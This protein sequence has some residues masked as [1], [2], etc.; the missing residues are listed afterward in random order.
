MK[1]SVAGLPSGHK[2]IEAH[3][4]S[5]AK[6]TSNLTKPHAPNSGRRMPAIRMKRSDRKFK[7]NAERQAAYR[8][9]KV[10]DVTLVTDIG[11]GGID[12]TEVKKPF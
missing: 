9:R 8:T 7:T 2:E 3:L 12:S 6:L 5:G 4:A 10:G 1:V 11:S